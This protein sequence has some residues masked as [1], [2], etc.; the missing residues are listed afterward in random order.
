MKGWQK[1]MSRP[2]RKGTAV[3]MIQ[4]AGIIRKM[5]GGVKEKTKKSHKRKKKTEQLK[6]PGERVQIDIKYVLE[7]CIQF[8][9]RAQKNYQIIA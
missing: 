9:T 4:Y 6:Y 8:G 1:S 3:H 5:K 2:E 7:E